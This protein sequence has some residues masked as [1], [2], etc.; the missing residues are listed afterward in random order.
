MQDHAPAGALTAS[1]LA[2]GGN[3]AGRPEEEIVKL[4]F[5]RDQGTTSFSSAIPLMSG[6]ALTCDC[7][8]N[9][10]LRNSP[11]IIPDGHWGLSTPG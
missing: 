10:C 7:Y 6:L 8:E 3:D 9:M 11:E 4:I 5:L 2:V 1:V